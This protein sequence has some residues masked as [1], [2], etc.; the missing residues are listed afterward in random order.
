MYVAQA[1]DVPITSEIEQAARTFIRMGDSALWF[2]ADLYAFHNMA[3]ASTPEE[4]SDQ[5]NRLQQMEKLAHRIGRA[6]PALVE[7]AKALGDRGFA[8]VAQIAEIDTLLAYQRVVTMAA[9][10]GG[11]T[12]Y[13]VSR[14]EESTANQDASQT[15]LERELLAMIPQS[16]DAAHSDIGCG[17][18]IGE[19]I[20]GAIMLTAGL[21][22]ENPL[23][24]AAGAAFLG[25]GTGLTAAF[26]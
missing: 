15:R 22:E 26:C 6:S 3:A 12:T 11:L 23:M 25:S 4:T 10:E 5:A 13:A 18:G 14:L 8:R 17:V 7:F 1:S 19:M 24:V 2:A 20:G 9:F 16:S 21:L